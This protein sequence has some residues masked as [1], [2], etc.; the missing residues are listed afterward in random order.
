MNN[1]TAEWKLDAEI[2][3][4]ELEGQNGF[5]AVVMEDKD[6]WNWQV[7]RTAGGATGLGGPAKGLEDGK[8]QAAWSLQVLEAVARAV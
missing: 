6:G 8:K 7:V 4:H 3:A 2:E 5:K 1:N